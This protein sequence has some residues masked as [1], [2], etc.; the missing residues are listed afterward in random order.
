MYRLSSFDDPWGK[1]ASLPP[2]PPASPSPD[3]IPL[4]VTYRRDCGC[5]YDH[6]AQAVILCKRHNSA[7]SAKHLVPAIIAALVIWGLLPLVFALTERGR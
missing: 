4:P 7:F 1:A 5:L 2:A 6:Q 3:P